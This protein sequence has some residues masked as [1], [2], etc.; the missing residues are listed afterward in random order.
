M[1]LTPKQKKE[2]QRRST[3]AKT[4]MDSMRSAGDYAEAD[5]DDDTIITDL[6]ANLMHYCDAK[7]VDFEACL[8]MANGHHDAEVDGEIDA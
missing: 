4:A 2:I 7:L 8:R 5:S 1:K 3:L 6:L